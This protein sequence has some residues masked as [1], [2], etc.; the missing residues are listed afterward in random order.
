MAAR[1]AP[2]F[3]ADESCDFSVVR[4]LRAHGFDVKAVV[5]I[6]RGAPDE[7]VIE[8]AR[9]EQRILI[10]EDRDF[11]RLVFASNRGSAGVI[12]IRFSAARRSELPDRILDIIERHGERLERSFTVLSADYLRVTS[13]P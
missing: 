13:L 2:R 9:S 8:F 12:F 10:T 3:L 1:A 5:E 11:G 4:R 7:S 6:D